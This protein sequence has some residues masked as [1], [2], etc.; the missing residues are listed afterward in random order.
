MLNKQLNFPN[1][2]MSDETDNQQLSNFVPFLSLKA[3]LAIQRK[4]Q[5]RAIDWLAKEFQIAETSLD[6][7]PKQADYKTL[8]AIQVYQQLFVQ[9]KDCIYIRGIDHCSTWEIQKLLLK[10]KQISLHYHK[11]III[12]THNLDLLQFHK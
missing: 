6:V 9:H 10:L 5:Q 7:L 2:Q 4:N 1:I 3:H 12:L 8:I 11:P